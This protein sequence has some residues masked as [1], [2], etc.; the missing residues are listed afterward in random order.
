MVFT[1]GVEPTT[2]RLSTLR[3]YQLGHVNEWTARSWLSRPSETRTKR[4]LHN[5]EGLPP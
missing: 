4:G 5:Y 1:V 3:L 2:T